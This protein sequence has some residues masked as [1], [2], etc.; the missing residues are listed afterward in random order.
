MCMR[1]KSIIRSTFGCDG[2]LL[3]LCLFCFL[4]IDRFLFHGNIYETKKL[5][6]AI[7]S[8]KLANVYD[9]R[10]ESPFLVPSTTSVARKAIQR[11]Y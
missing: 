8:R 10:D 5:V 3:V 9:T 11:L 4:Q 2:L 7:V 6:V 1:N